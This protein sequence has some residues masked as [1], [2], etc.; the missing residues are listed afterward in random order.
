MKISIILEALTA[1][2]ETDMQRA[3]KSV[4]RAFKEMK[5]SA[6][7]INK[8]LGAALSVGIAAAVGGVAYAVKSAVDEMDRMNKVSQKIGVTTEAL[9][10]LEYAAKL[11]DVEAGQLQASITKLSKAQ[12]D[13]AQGGKKQVELFRLLGVEFAN[14]DGTLRK[15]DQVFVDVA[16]RFS[17]M[18]D[19]AEKTALA[20]QL[21]GKAGAA[22]IPLLNGGA[23]GIR[24]AT[25]ELNE[26]GGVVST[27]AAR[28]AEEFNDQLS[29][30]GQ[31]GKGAGVELATYMLPTLNDLATEVLTLAKDPA[32]KSDMAQAIRTIGE[33]AIAASRGIVTFANN[34]GFLAD[35][36]KQFFG[37]VD[38][39]DLV[40]L[41]EQLTSLNGQLAILERGNGTEAQ[42]PLAQQLRAQI[43][44]VE[45]KIAAAQAVIGNQSRLAAL[46]LEE[47]DP[48]L[49]PPKKQIDAPVFRDTTAADKA[50]QDAEREA[51]RQAK[52]FA[53]EQE[54]Y[55]QTVRDLK[56]QALGEEARAVA[57]LQDDYADLNKAVELGVV[58]QQQAA[59]IAAGLAE[60]WQK[61]ATDS[62]RVDLLTEEQRA[63]EE[64]QA[65]YISLQN[66]IASG[67][68]TPE[69]GADRAAGLAEKWAEEEA[70]R[71]QAQIDNLSSGLLTEEELIQQSYERRRD[72]ILT[73]LDQESNAKLEKQ[74]ELNALLYANEEAHQQA[75][76][77]LEFAKQQEKLGLWSQAFGNLATLMNTENRKLFN[78]GKAAAIAGVAIDTAS[79]A[80]KAYKE[81]G[82]YLGPVF[83]A[84]A[85]A[86]GAVQIGNIMGTEYSGAYDR[87]GNIPAGGYGLVG[88]RGP[89]LIAGPA[90]VTSRMQTAS[91]LQRAADGQREIPPQRNIFVFSPE[92]MANAIAATPAGERMVVTHVNRNRNALRI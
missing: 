34:V 16:E 14:T 61:G 71:Y 57:A 59:E 81:G 54:K 15:A 5:R 3:Q 6:A 24:A 64:L 76:A 60:Q 25:D 55:T 89:E 36:V 91:M 79:A 56:L 49:I 37:I 85:V 23:Q 19:G 65:K 77:D 82:A 8:E 22:L 17:T 1:D 48:R 68:I 27:E 26:F 38:D 20:V 78:I 87:G 4:D 45:A 53:A 84:A 18:R 92:E 67:A 72:E 73:A 66:Q 10:A 69:M 58:S 43:A 28:A 40:R 44:E 11:A 74:S 80:M 88:E 70:A 31:V 51:R 42:S 33:A 29:R 90:S 12:A 13:A 7:T 62:I 2:F 41:D 21:F 86:A 9:S 30:L 75:M 35:E 39:D 83:A 32:F 50:A 52:E 47:V 63:V 46:G